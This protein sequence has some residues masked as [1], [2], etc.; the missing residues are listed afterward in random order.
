MVLLPRDIKVEVERNS[1][2]V[3]NWKIFLECIRIYSDFPKPSDDWRLKI[4]WIAALEGNKESF[5]KMTESSVDAY[6]LFKFWSKVIHYYVIYGATFTGRAKCVLA[7][8]ARRK[9]SG[10]VGTPAVA[11]RY[12]EGSWFEK[13]HPPDQCKPSLHAQLESRSYGDDS[14]F[15]RILQSHRRGRPDAF[16]RDHGLVFTLRYF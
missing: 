14:N 9:S 11:L 16:K 4:F 7:V 8:M 2:L 10:C 6:D 3:S 5:I 15:R 12:Q 13:V 1:I